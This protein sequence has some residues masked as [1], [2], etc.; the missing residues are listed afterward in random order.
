MRI[1][2][3]VPLKNV[4]I[5]FT[6][7]TL[8]K[9]TLEKR[10]RVAVANDNQG[11]WYT[12]IGG[13]SIADLERRFAE[14]SCS[15]LLYDVMGGIAGDPKKVLYVQLKMRDRLVDESLL[16]LGIVLMQPVKREEVQFI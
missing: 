10:I 8:K 3:R 11:Q 4:K 5:K 12:A 1:R 2:L 14:G 16:Y 6:G 9:W 13:K 7:S 15:R